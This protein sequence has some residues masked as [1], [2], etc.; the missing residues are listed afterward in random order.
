M[1]ALLYLKNIF[2]ILFRL[3]KF[4]I[5]F[6]LIE[7]V[8]FPFCI[9]KRGSCNLTLSFIKTLGPEACKRETS[10]MLVSK[11]TVAVGAWVFC[12]VT[13]HARL[14][15]PTNLATNLNMRKRSDAVTV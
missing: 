11:V 1:S 5:L 8:V 15:V 9:R 14:F 13:G 10:I 12:S 6:R 4:I 7:L 3:N 2:V